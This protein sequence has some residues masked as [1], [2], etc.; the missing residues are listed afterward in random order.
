M[1]FQQRD[2]AIRKRDKKIKH[3]EEIIARP[4]EQVAK[5]AG[6][7]STAGEQPMNDSNILSQVSSPPVPDQ[8]R[9][10]KPQF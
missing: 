2:A 4:C 7:P 1:F 5:A 10:V 3:L 8:H 6:W 9:P